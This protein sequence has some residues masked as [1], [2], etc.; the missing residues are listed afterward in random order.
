MKTDSAEGKSIE[1]AGY[2]S[3]S[4]RSVSQ[5]VPSLIGRLDRL[6]MEKV[7]DF[8]VKSWARTWK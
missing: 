4:H 2:L 1:S 5:T 7:Y 3:N 6:V 8:E